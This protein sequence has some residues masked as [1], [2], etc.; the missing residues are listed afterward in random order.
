[1]V[2]ST[3]HGIG[4]SQ[5]PVP[6]HTNTVLGDAQSCQNLLDPKSRKPAVTRASGCFLLVGAGQCRTPNHS[7]SIVAGGLLDTS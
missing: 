6:C 4:L 5:Y 2:S 1:M 3:E 7:H